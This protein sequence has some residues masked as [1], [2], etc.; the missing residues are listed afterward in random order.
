MHSCIMDW[1]LLLLWSVSTLGM[2]HKAY[3]GSAAR[4]SHQPWEDTATGS[5]LGLPSARSH[6]M[7]DGKLATQ[8]AV[9]DVRALVGDDA[10]WQLCTPTS[11]FDVE[12][13]G[14]PRPHVE[15]ARSSFFLACACCLHWARDCMSPQSRGLLLLPRRQLELDLYISSRIFAVR[16]SLVAFLMRLSCPLSLMLEDKLHTWFLAT[17]SKGENVVCRVLQSVRARKLQQT[18]PW[19]CVFVLK[20]TPCRGGFLNNACAC[21]VLPLFAWIGHC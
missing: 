6:C 17:V 13:A 14:V 8:T 7:V 4:S 10:V 3:N 9:N 16:R 15:H 5:E 18:G 2:N 12:P 1:L 20:T 11:L 19:G 21:E